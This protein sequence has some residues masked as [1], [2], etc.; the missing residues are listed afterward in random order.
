MNKV[1]LFLYPIEIYMKQFVLTEEEIEETR[2]EYEEL[3]LEYKV[4]RPLPILNECIQKRYRD[5]GYQI[6]FL[7]FKDK[8][9]FGLDFKDEDK[10]VYTEST[11]EELFDSKKYPS[12]EDI[13]NKIGQVDELVVSGYHALDCVER[14]AS[15]AYSIGID[16][17][18]DLDLTEFFFPLIKGMPHREEPYL[19]VNRY[20]K[21]KFKKDKINFEMFLGYTKDSAEKYFNETYKNPVFGFNKKDKKIKLTVS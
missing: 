3:G 8:E 9:L 4:V 1:F 20:D 2:K 15:Y 14:V 12:E 17:S 18:V 19:D 13:I 16:T 7:L 11:F 10:K 21:E 6:I 5:N